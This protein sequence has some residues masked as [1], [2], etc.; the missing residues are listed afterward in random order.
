M[1]AI[2]QGSL[3][4][5]LSTRKSNTKVISRVDRHLLTRVPDTS[6]PTDVLHPSEITGK[7]WCLRASYHLLRGA[8]PKRSSHPLRTE[9]VFHTGHD[10]HDKWQDWLAQEGSL[11]GDYKCLVCESLSTRSVA[12][13]LGY[14]DHECADCGC[15]LWKYDEMKMEIPSLRIV[16]H[17]DGGLIWGGIDP[18]FSIMDQAPDELLEIKS[19]GTGTLR[20]YEPSLLRGG[21]CLEQAFKNITR[22]FGGHILQVQL[23]LEAQ[24]LKLGDRAPS[25]AVV[26]YECKSNQDV[27]EFTVERNRN[28]IDD[29]LDKAYD[30]VQMVDA[31]EEPPCSIKPDSFCARCKEFHK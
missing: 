18:T 15:R 29:V 19:V 1:P 13:S 10:I 22:P 24:R 12:R 8:E 20:V 2:T 16:G 3:K 27:K 5:F 9:N 11:Y 21:V 23:Y 30:L 14:P 7:D 25:S 4:D 17:T 26:L 6:R 31:G 28:L